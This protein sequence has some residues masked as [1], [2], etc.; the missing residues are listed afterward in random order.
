[1]KKP[2]SLLLALAALPLLGGCHFDDEFSG[3]HNHPSAYVGRSYHH[4]EGTYDDH[5]HYDDR[6]HGYGPDHH[7]PHHYDGGHDG[8]Y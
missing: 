3:H 6:G 4:D 8:D 7:A 2:L 1:M 5:G